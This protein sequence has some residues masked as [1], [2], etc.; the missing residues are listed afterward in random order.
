MYDV[1]Y[2]TNTAGS[3]PNVMAAAQE[4]HVPAQPKITVNAVTPGLVARN[5]AAQESSVTNI[6][7]DGAN[8]SG[9]SARV[10]RDG[11]PLSE[12]VANVKDAVDAQAHLALA[13][14]PAT[15]LGPAQLV[16][17]KPGFDDA[18][19]EIRVV[20]QSEFAL[21]P[22]TVG[23]WHLDE[24]EEGVAHLFDASENAINLTS[25]QSSRVAEGRFGGGR[26]LTRA[27]ADAGSQA[28]ALGASSFTV[29]GW[30]KT[31]ALERDY[32]LIGK[33]TN[34]GQN[35]DF[36]L[37]ALS[38]GGLRAEVYDASGLAWQVE[39][40]PGTVSLTDG[41]W[42]CSGHGCRS[43]SRNTLTLR[44]WANSLLPFLLR[45]DSQACAISASL[46]NSV[47]STP[48]RRQATG[49]KNSPACWMNFAFPRRPMAPKRL[50]RTSLVTMNRR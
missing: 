38:S 33:E 31:S 12:V 17:S 18:T 3:A 43:R 37:K 48:T 6:T 15:P 49:R 45:W 25:A 22:D 1:W 20:E 23:L 9:V 34:T 36:T 42:H 19:A 24:R 5:K 39:T 44:R 13:V 10:M 16:L 26:T 2:G 41:W 14:A 35:T 11:Q 4:I 8:L 21:E 46:S 47:A 29:E 30:V 27:T 28:L 40:L 7:I 50:P 32:V